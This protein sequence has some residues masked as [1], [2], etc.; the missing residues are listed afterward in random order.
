VYAGV[1][2]RFPNL[3]RVIGHGGEG[4]PCNLYR[5]DRAHPVRSP[6]DRSKEL[7]SYYFKRNVFITN[8]GVAWALLV[9]FA[10]AV[11]GVDQVPYAM[12][13]PYQYDITEVH[14]MDA[15]PISFEAKKKFV[16]TNA[17]HVFNLHRKA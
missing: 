2:D 15:L 3:K 11:L 17:E 12:D 14:A 6:D 8:S 4:I 9:P 10:Q 16:P 5:V 1:F 13:Y 7:P